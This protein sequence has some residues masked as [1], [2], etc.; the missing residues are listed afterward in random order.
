MHYDGDA[1]ISYAHLDNIGL[2][3]GQ[4]GWI[5]GLQRALEIRVAQLLG[6]HT[7]VW[8]DP[9]LQGNDVFAETLIER[10]RRVAA[11]VPVLSPRYV[12][13]EWGRKE[14]VAFIEAAREQGGL[15]VG[16]K[17]RIFKV[18]KTPVPLRGTSAGAAAAARLRVLPEG[19]GDR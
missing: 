10:L 14:L 8:W 7:E 16:D 19:P 15:T 3:E 2:A 18:L 9:K 5:E 4:K 12:K 13:S 11:L 1:F 17:S 6:K